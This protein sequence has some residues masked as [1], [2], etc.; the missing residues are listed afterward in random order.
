MYAGTGD[1]PS[2]QRC[3]TQSVPGSRVVKDMSKQTYSVRARCPWPRVS[4]CLCLLK[5]AAI[6]AIFSATTTHAEA[7]VLCT[8]LLLL[9]RPNCGRR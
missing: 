6:F 9:S 5:N 8:T 7:A 4:C 3:K 1:E 2:I